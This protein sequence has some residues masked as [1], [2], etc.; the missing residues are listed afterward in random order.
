MGKRDDQRITALS[1]P[2]LGDHCGQ[3]ARCICHEHCFCSDRTA[4]THLDHW[5][6][7]CTLE[8]GDR[9]YLALPV[10]LHRLG[11]ISGNTH[12]ATTTCDRSR[13]RNIYTV[14]LLEWCF[15][16]DFLLHASHSIYC[17]N[18]SPLLC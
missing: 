16:T 11:N 13:F 8:R 1:C 2:S 17:K 6:T 5:C 3:D 18:V 4:G 9:L 10:H 14:V 12:K 7:A 15:W